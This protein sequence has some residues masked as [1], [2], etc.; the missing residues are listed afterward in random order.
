M[1]NESERTRV[2]NMMLELG[3]DLCATLLQLLSI[4]QLRCPASKANSSANLLPS[5][6]PNAL[7]SARPPNAPQNVLLSAPLYLP[8]V[9]W[10]LGVAA[11]PALGVAVVPALG[12]AAALG[13]VAAA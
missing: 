6:P 12:A 1:G 2:D 4:H 13:V 5:A 10:V 8:A 7:Q 3:S 11:A 9:A